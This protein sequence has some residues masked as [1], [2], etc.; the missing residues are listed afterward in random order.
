MLLLG[1][2]AGVGVGVHRENAAEIGPLGGVFLAGIN[3]GGC[4]A[5]LGVI[6]VA[7]L[8]ALWTTKY[9]LIILSIHRCFYEQ[10]LF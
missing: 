1:L 2:G 6:V 8:L 5:E 7:H 9:R 3:T 4:V 10:R